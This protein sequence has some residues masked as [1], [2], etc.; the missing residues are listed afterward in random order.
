MAAEALAQLRSSVATLADLAADGSL[1]G[2]PAAGLVELAEGVHRCHDRLGAVAA[3]ATRT[4]HVSD[5]LSVGR[6]VSTSRWLQVR[7]GK[8]PA[9]A[10]A[11]VARSY[12]VSGRFA[13]TEAAWLAGEVSAGAV[14]EITHGITRVVRGRSLADSATITAQAQETLLQVARTGTVADVATTVRHLRFVL[15]PD[16]ASQAQVDAYDDQQLTFREVGTMVELTGYLS[17]ETAAKVRTALEATVDGWYRT[18]SLPG[19]DT[20]PAGSEDADTRR[21]RYRRPH[22]LALALADLATRT[23]DAGALGT[24][25]RVRPHLTV[26]VD[27]ERLLAGW[28]GELAVP[29]D[30]RVPLP[31][32]TVRRIMCDADLHPVITTGAKRHPARQRCDR[33]VGRARGRRRA[34]TRRRWRRRLARQPARRPSATGGHGAL[35]G[36][37]LPDPPAAA[38]PRARGPRWTLRVP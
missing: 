28:G 37:H 23:L 15:D 19:E 35:G 30:D 21:R 18:G 13:R 16:G 38:A 33:W 3:A 9:E 34:P 20:A 8:S 5:A 32:E 25:H 11:L 2:I 4:V 7:C 14:R 17:Q 26:N 24:R 31:P 10:R 29:G 12:D 36:A 22:L 1:A 6:Q 27:L